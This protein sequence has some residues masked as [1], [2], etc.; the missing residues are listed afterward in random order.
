MIE[1][2]IITPKELYKKLE[3]PNQRE[4]QFGTKFE[5]DPGD[6]IV[7]EE[8]DNGIPTGNTTEFRALYVMRDGIIT[9]VG[10]ADSESPIFTRLA[11][12]IN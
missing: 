7:M 2:R 5:C 4:L 8:Y 9:R 1:R 10:L 12:V 11:R 6:L 3:D